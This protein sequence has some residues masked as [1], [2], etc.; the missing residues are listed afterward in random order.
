[1]RREALEHIE[2]IRGTAGRTVILQWPRWEQQRR[3]CYTELRKLQ[4]AS[5]IPK[6]RQFPFQSFRK[7]H[8]TVIASGEVDPNAGIRTAQA[9]AGHT[10]SAV[11]VGHYVSGTVQDRLVA[12]AI[13]AM[14]S[15]CA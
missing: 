12:A 5:G 7:T 4:T 3:T 6:H 9:S 13:D 14:P 15:P 10:S 2:K 8:L 1:L 11:T